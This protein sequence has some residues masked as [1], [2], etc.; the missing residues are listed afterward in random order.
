[1]RLL[2]MAML[3][4]SGL[5]LISCS[6]NQENIKQSDKSSNINVELGITY[7]KEGKY[8]T[9]MDRLQKAIRQN[10]GNPLAYSSLALLQMRLE[11][12]DDAEK[13]FNKAITLAPTNSSIKNNYGTFLCQQKRYPEAQEQFLEATK[14][15]LYKTPE[16]AYLNA[17][18][19]TA[20]KALAE[21]YFRAALRRNPTLSGALLEMARLSLELKRYL[22]ARAY[23]QRYHAERE[24][25]AASLWASVQVEKQLGDKTT[26]HKHALLLQR[27]FPDSEETR[28]YLQWVKK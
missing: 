2:Q 4:A 21:K 20:D 3:I 14:N 13:N 8:D 23:L 25:D 10:P 9:A 27:K 15:P 6:A 12:Q 22:S 24:P 7:M 18:K 5:S 11:Q 16:H 19:C 17:G 1:M 26:M 28:Q